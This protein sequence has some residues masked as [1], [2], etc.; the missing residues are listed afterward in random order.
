LKIAKKSFFFFSSSDELKEEYN[1]SKVE[2]DKVNEHT[3]QTIQKRKSMQIE[4]KQFLGQ[5]E[6]VERFERLREEKVY[7]ARSEKKK[8]NKM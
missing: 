6:E 8:N 3:L 7:Y 2:M 1:A 5:K 4:K